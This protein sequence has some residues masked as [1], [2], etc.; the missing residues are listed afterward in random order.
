M[1]TLS[2]KL[3]NINIISLGILISLLPAEIACQFGVE[4]HHVLLGQSEHCNQVLVKVKL[5]RSFEVPT[6]RYGESALPAL[7]IELLKLSTCVH[8]I[9]IILTL[10]AIN[11]IKK[12]MLITF[13]VSTSI[14]LL[15]RT[16]SPFLQIHCSC[17]KGS[18]QVVQ[19]VCIYGKS[20]TYGT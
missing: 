9:N 4:V 7:S 12:A 20:N 13:L 17:Q 5:G 8:N 2:V 11:V 10:F 1:F 6:L 15:T 19:I 16:S 3:K 18:Y 14:L